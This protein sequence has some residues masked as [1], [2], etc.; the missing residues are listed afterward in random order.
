MAI[1]LET[2]QFKISQRLQ[3]EWTGFLLRMK[4]DENY[5]IACE[6]AIGSGHLITLAPI[7]IHSSVRVELTY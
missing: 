6:R 4:T 2:I 7:N 1:T 3:E 5:K